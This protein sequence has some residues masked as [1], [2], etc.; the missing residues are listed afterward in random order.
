MNP[1][2]LT[3]P[4]R[5]LRRQR[6]LRGWTL[7]QVV[8]ELCKLC[9]EEDD[10]PGVTADMVS[11]WEREERKPSRFYQ[12]KLCVLYGKSADQL[13]FIETIAMPEP[14]QTNS[15]NSLLPTP[16]FIPGSSV[17]TRTI[18]AL[19]STEQAQVSEALSTTILSQSSQQLAMLTTLG[20]T[21]Q[22]IINAIQIV[23]QGETAMATMNRRQ[24]LQLGAGMLLLGGINIPIHEH[25]S[26][27][28]RTQLSE[29]LGEGIVAGWT[30]FHVA[31]TAQVLAVSQAQITQVNQ[32][33]SILYPGALPFLYS[34]AYRLMGA[35]LYFQERY[36]DA[37]RVHEHAYRAAKETL[38]EW[39]IAQSLS[40]LGYVHQERDQHSDAIQVIEEALHL[41]EKR[42]DEAD[43]RL[44]A[45]LLACWAENAMFLQEK[46]IA[47][48]K[49]AASA[50]LLDHIS[51]NEEF[52]RSKWLQHAGNI[53]L[54]AGE[55]TT[56]IDYF[57]E[58]LAAIQPHWMLRH[59]V[60][61]IPLAIAYARKREQE[62]SLAV[63][64]KAVPVL[65]AMKSPIMNKQFATYVHE[66][67]LNAYP[68]DTHVRAFVTEAQQLLP[69]VSGYM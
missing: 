2:P 6:L 22:D 59:A 67:L 33:H 58:A 65:A 62:A 34:G 26:T 17:G 15:S 29:A 27:V 57:E 25:P 66:D 37:L 12:S 11:K 40:W 1:I 44:K 61:F 30:L 24:V 38:D 16:T 48:E 18:D 55:H 53:A 19:L 51:A 46:D 28:E 10:V 5:L 68:G 63:A 41:I 23:L 8:D 13:G 36:E 21:Q 4:N 64:K 50:A 31:S 56:A 20:W 69:Q 54:T 52:D 9:E 3:K 49:L 45:H 47:K 35:A 42:I 14:S 32:A 39:N 60:T 43:I 7:K